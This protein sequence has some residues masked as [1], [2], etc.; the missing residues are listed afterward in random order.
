MTLMWVNCGGNEDAR[1]ALCSPA[2]IRQVTIPDAFAPP[3]SAVMDQSPQ[4]KD[5]ISFD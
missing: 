4:P 5:P 1:F 2:M 3:T